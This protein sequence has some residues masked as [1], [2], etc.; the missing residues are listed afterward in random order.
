[1]LKKLAGRIFG[2]QTEIE[3]LQEQIAQ[4]SMD[5]VFGMWTRNAFLQFS[6]IM[7]RGLRVVVFLDLD[8]LHQLNEQY[9]YENV[10]QRIR[11]I[12]S[13]PFRRSDLVARWFSG[14]EIVVLFDADEEFALRKIG[15]LEEAARQQGMSFHFQLAIWD[16][17]KEPIEKVID[18][19]SSKVLAEKSWKQQQVSKSS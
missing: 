1:M 3:Q 18:E 7:P 2:F 17:G 5:P 15:Q 9:G 12:F 10:N 16:V 8:N 11:A 19:L 13:I 14:D 6:L 4:L